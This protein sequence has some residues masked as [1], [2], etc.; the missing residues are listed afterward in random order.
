LVC[1][2]SALIP[3]PEASVAGRSLIADNFAVL[4]NGTILPVTAT[5]SF[6]T[7]GNANSLQLAFVDGRGGGTLQRNYVRDGFGLISDQDRNRFEAAARFQNIWKQHTFKYGFEFNENRYSIDTTSSGPARTF[8]DPTGQESA[9]NNGGTAP[10]FP[11]TNMPGGIR[12]T[13]NFGACIAVSATAAQCPAGALTTRFNALIA[14]GQGPA[15]ITTVTTNAGLTAAQLSVNPILILSSVRVRDFNLSTRGGTT[16]T[17]TESF[18]IQDDV[19]LSRDV[20]LNLGV[21]WDFQQAYGTRSA[22]IKLNDFID[23]LQPRIGFIYDFTGKGRGKVFANYARFLE[24]PIPLDV[25]VRAGGD[26]IQIDRL[27]NVNLLN[28]AQGSVLIAGTAGGLGCLGCSATPVDPDLK[29]QTV[30]E[31]ALGFEYEAVKDLTV[32]VRGVYRAQGSVIEDG[33]FDDGHFYFL[34]NPGESLTDRLAATPPCTGAAGE[35]NVV[36]Q[37]TGAVNPSGNCGGAGVRFGRARR[38]YR[39]L[40]FTATK[41]FTND[42]QFIASYVFSSLTGNYEGLFRNDNGQSDPNITSLF[43]LPSL[44][45]NTYGRLPNDRPHQFKFNGTYR[46]PF[47]LVVSGNFYAQS[48]IPFNALIPHDV[49]GN[50]EGFNVQR[51]TAINPVTGK[52]RTPT[53]YQ[54]DFGFYYPIAFSEKRELRFQLD[55]FNVT[56]A[57]RALRE[58]ETLRINSGIPGAQGIQFPNASFGTGQ[59]FQFPSALRLGAKFS[60]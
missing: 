24:T 50:N 15:G 17:R 1:T 16:R 51:G 23:N 2:C 57:Q 47:K 46:T 53:T 7:S 40:E 41:R 43:D 36:N 55:W 52:S 19:K 11:A 34:F 38:Y 56:N 28:A 31:F 12:V 21:R 18:Y 6:L 9:A 8:G 4:R 26:D 58:D 49:Y 45:G 10:R 5:N 32:G 33:S 20:M 59:I 29:P 48:G 35:V 60:F 54:L 14:A 22:Y 30:N 37:T 25:N 44:L 27:A 3:I 39:A 42:F 13:N